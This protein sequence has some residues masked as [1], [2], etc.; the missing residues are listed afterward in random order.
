[1]AGD[2]GSDGS[3][4]CIPN[5]FKVFKKKT[6]HPGP[7]RQAVEAR[8]VDHQRHAVRIDDQ[9]RPIDSQDQPIR[10]SILHQRDAVGGDTPSIASQLA[11]PADLYGQVIPL[12]ILTPP[13]SAGGTP[14][15]GPSVAG[16]SGAGPSGAGPRPAGASGGGPSAASEAA[17]PE[18]KDG[19]GA[20]KNKDAGEGNLAAAANLI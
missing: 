10:G 16:P 18:G 8:D 13:S 20:E 4:C 15:G 9:G 19:N 12:D 11:T 17:S 7:I 5:P 3:F 6:E 2:T 1:M 14:G